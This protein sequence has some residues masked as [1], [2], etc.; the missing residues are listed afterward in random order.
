MFASR[1]KN[2]KS[3][4]TDKVKDGQQVLASS[5]YLKLNA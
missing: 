2:T 5:I 4:H 3:I 1:F